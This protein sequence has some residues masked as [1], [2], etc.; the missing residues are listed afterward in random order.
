[1]WVQSI[2]DHS[3]KLQVLVQCILGL[4]N[5]YAFSFPVEVYRLIIFRPSALAVPASAPLPACTTIS[6]F[7]GIGGLLLSVLYENCFHA[8]AQ[9][10]D[11]S[12]SILYCHEGTPVFS[13]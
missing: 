12:V 4:L 7:L 13:G 6:L 2:A 1:M 9:S 10:A 5:L 3:A 8:M 11:Y